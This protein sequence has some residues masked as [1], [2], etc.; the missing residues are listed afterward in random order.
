MLLLTKKASRRNSI[1]ADSAAGVLESCRHHLHKLQQPPSAICNRVALKLMSMLKP[2]IFFNIRVCWNVLK[3]FGS[4]NNFL[5][6]FLIFHKN[7]SNCFDGCSLLIFQKEECDGSSWKAS[8][9][10]SSFRH[11][12]S[13]SWTEAGEMTLHWK[14]L[15]QLKVLQCTIACKSLEY[16]QTGTLKWQNMIFPLLRSQAL[17]WRIV[18]STRSKDLGLNSTIRAPGS[19]ELEEQDQ[20][21]SCRCLSDTVASS[22]V[23]LSQ[24]S[25]MCRWVKLVFHQATLQQNK[26]KETCPNSHPKLRWVVGAKCSFD[27]PLL[28]FSAITE[29]RNQWMCSFAQVFFFLKPWHKTLSKEKFWQFVRQEDNGTQPV[30]EQQWFQSSSLDICE[31]AKCSDFAGEDQHRVFLCA[32]NLLFNRSWGFEVEINERFCGQ[33]PVDT[34]ELAARSISEVPCQPK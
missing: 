10:Y 7:L 23:S 8:T 25:E 16:W 14:N 15:C 17:P 31:V 24:V 3:T 12:K 28:Y 11:K 30:F 27:V 21:R 9:S 26:T 19:E 18:T 22:L 20:H 13:K 6:V 4:V 32:N 29:N 5:A 2:F 1:L 33:K 34:K